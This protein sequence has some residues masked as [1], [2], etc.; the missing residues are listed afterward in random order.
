MSLT[1]CWNHTVALNPKAIV[2]LPL[3]V[4]TVG[5]TARRQKKKAQFTSTRHIASGSTGNDNAD[6]NEVVVNRSW[7]EDTTSSPT[8]P[9]SSLVVVFGRRPSQH[10]LAMHTLTEQS[11]LFE[12]GPDVHAP[13][14]AITRRISEALAR[15]MRCN[16]A[17]DCL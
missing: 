10:S 4:V 13:T 9:V 12:I 16:L 14:S 8:S 17:S 5:T 7:I 3:P 6:A 1:C 11:G 2:I 15:A